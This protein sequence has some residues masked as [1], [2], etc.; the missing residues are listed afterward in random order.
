MVIDIGILPTM[1]ILMGFCPLVMTNIA[2][3]HGLLK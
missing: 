3:E 1:G 2:I